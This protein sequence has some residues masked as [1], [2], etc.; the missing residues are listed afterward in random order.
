MRVNG[1]GNLC[2]DVRAEPG[3]RG[4]RAHAQPLPHLVVGDCAFAAAAQSNAGEST[5]TQAAG[6]T[7]QP[8]NVK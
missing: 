5:L 3:E 2:G 7:I 1:G 8:A 4:A 6:C